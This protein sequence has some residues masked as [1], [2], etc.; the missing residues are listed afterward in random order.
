[1][2]DL[3]DT[4]K[5]IKNDDDKINLHD[6]FKNLYNNNNSKIFSWNIYNK[7]YMTSKIDNNNIINIINNVLK[8]IIFSEIN[9]NKNKSEVNT[10]IFL[11]KYYNF[12][13]I[14][15][16]ELVYYDKK[17][18][19]IYNIGFSNLAKN[20]LTNNIKDIS[21]KYL[22]NPV[23]NNINLNLNILYKFYNNMDDNNE[24]NF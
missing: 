18:F 22:L 13:E 2:L 10:K 14:L 3:F 15:K 11:L 1:M 24:N 20:Y 19:N 21:K 4:I 17:I 6:I 12:I 16:L 23:N 7:I 8:E 5:P 9:F